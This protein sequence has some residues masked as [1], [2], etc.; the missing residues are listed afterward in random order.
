VSKP[1]REQRIRRGAELLRAWGI[2]EDA[3]DL[4][5]A[6]GRDPDADIAIA[7]QLGAVAGA[8]SVDILQGLESGAA[9]KMVRKE[10][11]RS[12]YR[13]EQRGVEVERA[14]PEPRKITTGSA[15][16]DGYLSPVDGRGDQLVWLTKARTGGVLHLFAVCNDP[17][18][19]KDLN[20]AEV[21]RKGLRSLRQTLVDKHEIR[22]IEADW[23]YCDFLID[24]ALR[25]SN[26]RGEVG[27][28]YPGL[29]AQ[30]TTEPVTE[31]Q[32]L[33]FRHLDADVVRAETKLVEESAALLDE[34]ELRTW[35]FDRDAMLPYLEQLR[36]VR[37]SPLV[38]NE[39][40]Q[41]E[42]LA[43]IAD[44]A[45][46][47][48]FG[49]EHRPSWTRRLEELAYFFHAT[50]RAEQAKKALAA[51][52]ALTDSTVGGTDVPLCDQLCRTSLLAY[53]Q[54]EEKRQQEQSRSSL[55]VSPQQAV[56]EA[57][58][59]RRPKS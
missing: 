2:G 48:I 14:V 45:V 28:D 32:P 46:R 26:E 15:E 51:A 43:Q 3:G 57:E 9:D 13:L 36:E 4:G 25:R 37:D 35:F 34:K 29:R 6:V 11:K 23:R 7:A 8:A 56:R 52:I 33:I 40:Q 30:L 21:S 59:R 24:R 18:G 41:G 16:I 58:A 22:L 44:R 50:G 54:I 17:E 31:M 10:A 47:E 42:R 12:L 53:W 19:L 39:A 1:D 20:L 5:K 55:V 49:G 38:L 27:G